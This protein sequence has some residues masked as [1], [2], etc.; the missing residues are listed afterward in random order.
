MINLL[1]IKRKI[2][3]LIGRS[4]HNGRISFIVSYAHNRHRWPN[5][6]HPK[7]LSEIWIKRVLD[8]KVNELSHLA[9]KYAVREYVKS[10]VMECILTP[11]I[12]VY[13]SADEIDFDVLPK[14]FALKANFGAGMHFQIYDIFL[15]QYSSQAYYQLLNNISLVPRNNPP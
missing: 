2:L 9:D 3:G 15:Y 5:L 11:L 4:S 14:R 7:D 13:E 12:A 6:Q 8:G 1:K 10:K